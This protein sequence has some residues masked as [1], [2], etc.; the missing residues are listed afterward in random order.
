[1]SAARVALQAVVD[2]LRDVEELLVAVDDP[3]LD[4]EPGIR[5][6]RDERVVDLRDAAAEGGRGQVDDALA[7]E[8]LGE[9]ADLSIRPRVAMVA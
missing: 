8:G 1:M 3:P 9:P 7:L 4:V 5:H 2:R 6:Q